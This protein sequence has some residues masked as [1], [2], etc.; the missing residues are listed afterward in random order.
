[1]AAGLAPV[2][3][4]I[5]CVA[6]D[7]QPRERL[8]KCGAVREAA[9]HARRQLWLGQPRDYL[10]RLP[11]MLEIAASH[12]QH[13]E[14]D[15][16]VRQLARGWPA[17]KQSERH[18]QRTDQHRIRQIGRRRGEFLPVPI[19]LRQRVPHGVGRMPQFGR[20][21]LEQT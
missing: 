14:R 5:C 18:E 6:E 12:G 15:A 3:H 9:S 21:Q 4:Q 2:Q 17:P 20:D 1:L 10:K 11:Q 19:E 13:A 7:L 16:L 8:A